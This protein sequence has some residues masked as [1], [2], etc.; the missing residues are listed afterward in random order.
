[1]TTPPTGENPYGNNSPYGNQQPGQGPYGGTAPG[2]GQPAYGAPGYGAPG[3]GAP[4][5]GTQSEPGK[6][7]AIAALVLAFIACILPNIIS[8]VLA[9]I[10]LRRSKDG[11]DHGKGLAIAALVIDVLVILGWVGAIALGAL[12]LSGES[13][14]DLKTGQCLTGEGLNVDSNDPVSGIEV[15]ACDSGHDGEVVATKELSSEEADG[16]DIN[17]DTQVVEYCGSAISDDVAAAITEDI[18]IIGLTSSEEPSSGDQLACI[19]VGAD[20]AELTEKLG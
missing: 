15:V 20:G 7:M 8:A 14:D 13:V 19:A 12:S 9:I 1:M 4:G 16:Y 2:A 11:R 18:R 10:V 3:Y 5:Y 17:D 6:G